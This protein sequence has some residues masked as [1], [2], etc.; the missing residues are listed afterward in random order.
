MPGKNGSKA[1]GFSLPKI[2]ARLVFEDDYEG[3]EVVVRT[4]VPMSLVIEAQEVGASQDIG[5][6]AGSF[7]SDVLLDWNLLDDGEPVAQTVEGMKSLPF[8]FVA[9]ILEAWSSA[10][11]GVPVPLALKSDDGSTSAKEPSV[12][13]AQ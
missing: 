1:E 9:R 13:M 8:D 6:F 5:S 11:A 10:V 2:S 4:N 12:E 7:V 3:A